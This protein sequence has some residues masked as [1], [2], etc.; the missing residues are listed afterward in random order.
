MVDLR[1]AHALVVPV[2][3]CALL[4][5]GCSGD[6]DDSGSASPTAGTT[7]AESKPATASPTA[8]PTQA[9]QTTGAIG[10]TL[11]TASGVS[12]TLEAIES[13]PVGYDAMGEERPDGADPIQGYRAILNAA[14]VN[15]STESVTLTENDVQ[16]KFYIDDDADGQA[17]G[18]SFDCAQV[19]LAAAPPASRAPGEVAAGVEAGWTA[20]FVCPG[21]RLGTPVEAVY[22]VGGEQLTFTGELP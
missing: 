22:S 9:G 3:V 5:A 13:P 15:G 14:V 4:I 1:A 7:A 2:S 18:E 11:T 8:I 20:T 19:F 17:T 12:V 21:Q 10:D 16:L 6:S